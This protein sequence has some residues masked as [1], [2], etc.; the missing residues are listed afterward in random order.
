MTFSPGFG[1]TSTPNNLGQNVISPVDGQV[2]LTAENLTPPVVPG[3]RDDGV[4]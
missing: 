1:T 4:R 3:D 2:T